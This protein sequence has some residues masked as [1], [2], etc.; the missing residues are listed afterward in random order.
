MTFS[1]EEAED[2]SIQ[3]KITNSKLMRKIF[4]KYGEED[5]SGFEHLVLKICGAIQDCRD[6]ATKDSVSEQDL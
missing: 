3:L 1:I 6:V 4:K 2:D 5:L